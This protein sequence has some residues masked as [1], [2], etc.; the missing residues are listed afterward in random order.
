MA[1]LSPVVI[2]GSRITSN[3]GNRTVIFRKKDFKGR[4]TVFSFRTFYYREDYAGYIAHRSVR[5]VRRQRKKEEER[6]IE[7]DKRGERVYII[8]PH[9]K[10]F[11]RPSR[12]V[13]GFSLRILIFLANFFRQILLMGNE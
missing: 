7:R 8:F 12:Y 9:A 11:A 6:E 4:T 1:V 3:Y 13:Q 10:K 2:T 5:C